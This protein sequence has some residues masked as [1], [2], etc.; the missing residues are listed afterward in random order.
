MTNRCQLKSGRRS[1]LQPYPKNMSI[2]H[3][4][5][6]SK[7]VLA[8][9]FR[10]CRTKTRE[11][12]EGPRHILRWMDIDQ[13]LDH[14]RLLVEPK[15]QLNLEPSCKCA[16]LGTS[17]TLTATLRPSEDSVYGAKSSAVDRMATRGHVGSQAEGEDEDNYE[18]Y[19]E[20]TEDHESKGKA[21]LVSG[22]FDV[23]GSSIS[24]STP[25]ALECEIEH[26]EERR[27]RKS[28]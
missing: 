13:E 22:C 9:P 24:G 18:D 4:S 23:H 11:R 17:E 6:D 10:P 19:E 1:T 27:G 3:S 14:K 5:D 16:R 21:Y 7:K 20:K 15:E 12:E 28:Q 8:F 25:V 26:E 2:Q